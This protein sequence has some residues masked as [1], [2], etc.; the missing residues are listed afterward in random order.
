MSIEKVLDQALEM[1]KDIVAEIVCDSDDI[2]KYV[3]VHDPFHKLVLLQ[4]IVFSFICL[5]GKHICRMRN[6]EQ[7]AMVRHKKT[8]EVIFMH[9]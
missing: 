6:V 9:E 1:T 5:K 7:K 3:A 8:K 2:F 4:K